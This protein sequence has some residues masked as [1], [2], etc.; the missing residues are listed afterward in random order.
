MRGGRPPPP[1]GRWSRVTQRSRCLLDP[2][3]PFRRDVL[4]VSH[5]RVADRPPSQVVPSVPLTTRARGVDGIDVGDRFG[6]GDLLGTERE[7]EHLLGGGHLA[8]EARRRLHRVAGRDLGRGQRTGGPRR[9][10]GEEQGG[11]DGDQ[12]S[13]P[14]RAS[15]PLAGHQH[16]DLGWVL[17]QKRSQPNGRYTTCR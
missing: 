6:G 3:Q 1:A 17:Y 12:G 4:Q 5:Q 15:F 8:P 7:A 14:H 13:A 2:L 9:R 11:G 10:Q 16:P